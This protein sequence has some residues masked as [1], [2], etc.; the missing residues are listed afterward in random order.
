MDKPWLIP[1]AFH[2]L[3]RFSV[4]QSFSATHFRRRSHE[5]PWT[6]AIR[7]RRRSASHRHLSLWLYLCLLHVRCS[8]FL[9]LSHDKG[10][11]LRALLLGSSTLEI[12]LAALPVFLM[13]QPPPCSRTFLQ[14][15]FNQPRALSI[16]IVRFLKFKLFSPASLAFK[17]HA[18]MPERGLLFLGMGLEH[19]SALTV[20]VF[21]VGA[22]SKSMVA[23]RPL[24]STVT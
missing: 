18:M 8:I 5:R 17:A 21:P 23:R 22:S 24:N 9:F 12:T 11:Q 3:P 14:M 4:G 10:P 16:T 6:L 20:R 7:A 19:T 1:H 2:F 15:G 13:R